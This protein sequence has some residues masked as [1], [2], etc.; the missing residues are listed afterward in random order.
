MEHVYT[1]WLKAQHTQ[2]FQVVCSCGYMTD[3]QPTL[4]R[5]TNQHQLHQ[6]TANRDSFTRVLVN[7]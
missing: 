1:S 7:A 4:Q 3:H 6:T 2:T 5:A